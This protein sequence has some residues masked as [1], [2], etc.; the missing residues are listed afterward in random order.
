MLLT[1]PLRRWPQVVI[2]Q[3]GNQST[4]TNSSHWD[5]QWSLKQGSRGSFS[6]HCTTTVRRWGGQAS[7]VPHYTK[8]TQQSIALGCFHQPRRHL[9]CR[10]PLLKLLLTAIVQWMRELG[11]LAPCSSDQWGSSIGAPSDQ[12]FI[13]NPLV[14]NVN[15]VKTPLKQQISPG[16]C[17][18]Q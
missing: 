16:Y 17:R 2:Q 12:T 8:T 11:A 4:M 14:I 15:S 6:L 3:E 7:M 5:R 1:F 18:H 13:S 10:R 9:W